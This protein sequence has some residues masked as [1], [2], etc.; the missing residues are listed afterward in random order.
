[1]LTKSEVAAVVESHA[2]PGH[3][4]STPCL[5]AAISDL[6]RSKTMTAYLV[7]SG[8]AEYAEV[9]RHVSG[10]IGPLHEGLAKLKNDLEV[11]TAE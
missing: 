3:S 11:Y 6:A 7:I 4:C 1:M 8:M 2:V 9:L 10:G 5:S